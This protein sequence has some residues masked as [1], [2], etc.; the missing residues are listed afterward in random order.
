MHS[1]HLRNVPGRKSDVRDCQWI[2]QLHCYGLLKA[3]FRPSQD[4]CALRSIVR[5]RQML[6]RLAS[7]MGGKGGREVVEAVAGLPMAGFDDRQ[8]CLYEPAACGAL[9]AE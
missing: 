6:L 5:H 3:S 2:Q 9:R 7:E 4:L 8:D 1:E